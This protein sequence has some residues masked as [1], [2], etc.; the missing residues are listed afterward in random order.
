M[1]YGQ[2]KMCFFKINVFEKRKEEIFK[3]NIIIMNN[4]Y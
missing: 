4:Y 2:F 1:I 3:T